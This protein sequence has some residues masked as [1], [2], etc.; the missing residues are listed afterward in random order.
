MQIF[1]NYTDM[2]QQCIRHGKPKADTHSLGQVFFSIGIPEEYAGLLVFPKKRMGLTTYTSYAL[3]EAAWY[4]SQDR[5]VDWIS[6]YGPIW[7]NMVDNNG[8]VNSNYGYQLY[9]NNDLTRELKPYK[10]VYYDIL[11]YENSQSTTDVPCNNVVVAELKDN[12]LHVYSLA[13]SIDLIYGLPFDMIALQAF[14]Y[15]LLQQQGIDSYVSHVSF[16]IIDAHVYDN[17]IPKLDMTYMSNVFSSIRFID[18]HYNLYDLDYKL[19]N[20]REYAKHIVNYDVMIDE[21]EDISC[22]DYFTV[23][24][25]EYMPM[26]SYEHNNLWFE[27]D[28][29]KDI[30]VISD[31]LTYYNTEGITL[32]YW[33]NEEYD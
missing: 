19:I 21:N 30:K 1:S 20:Y 9:H 4:M 18:T 27:P 33:R 3:A 5:K 32:E 7:K 26:N 12:G 28:N 17:M 23:L 13:R 15:I 24:E 11:N 16:E 2:L 6:D 29:R 10:P 25:R 22:F 8:L 31:N 14:G